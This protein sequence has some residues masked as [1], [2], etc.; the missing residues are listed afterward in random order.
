MLHGT[1]LGRYRDAWMGDDPAAVSS[2][3][4]PAGER[5]EVGFDRVLR[6]RLEIEAAAR[7]VMGAF[8]ERR[9][10]VDPAMA[11]DFGWVAAVTL[12]AVQRGPFRGAPASG[13]AFQIPGL[14]I[15]R[16]E[17]GLLVREGWYF[18]GVA[19]MRLLGGRL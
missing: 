9:L 6:G 19:V 11:D 7:E 18:D 10:A 15:A 3:F 17:D 5:V 8:A 12:S 13:R 14:S 4:A 1:P 16:L 2:L